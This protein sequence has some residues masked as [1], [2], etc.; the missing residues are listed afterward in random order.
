MKTSEFH[1]LAID[2]DNL[3]G[4]E[5][6]DITNQVL[7]P[8][9]PGQGNRLVVPFIPY[10]GRVRIVG[11]DPWP[12]FAPIDKLY[13]EYERYSMTKMFSEL[14]D[15]RRWGEHLVEFYDDHLVTITF[16]APNNIRFG[17]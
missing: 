15:E 3:Y 6:I 2:G 8:L 13:V 5:T 14:V 7:R 10:L 17:R 12:D 4:M 16:V 9:P 11:H 1:K